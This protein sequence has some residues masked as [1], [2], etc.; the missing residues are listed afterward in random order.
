[1]HALALMMIWPLGVFSLLATRWAADVPITFA[2]LLLVLAAAMGLR[3]ARALLRVSP[4]ALE[5]LA[6][7]RVRWTPDTGAA[8]EGIALAH[9]QWPVTTLRFVAC[10]TTLVFWPDTLCASS[11][12]HLR[13]WSR[14][15]TPESPLPQ[16]W[17]G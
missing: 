14:S 4:G 6:E 2:A 13:R 17:M 16:F 8:V 7:G 15:A 9:E 1:V 5:L 11:R 10:G 3:A 12:R